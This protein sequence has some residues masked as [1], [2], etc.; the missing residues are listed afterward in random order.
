MGDPEE[1]LSDAERDQAVEW[2]RDHLLSG[3]LTLEEFS[4]R[5]DQAYAARVRADLQQLRLALPSPKEL[6]RG[7][8]HRRAT[9][10]TGAAFGKVVK[11]GRTKRRR[12]TVAGGAF[13]DVD[14]DLCQAA[15]QGRRTT[16]TVLVGLGNVDRL[17]AGERQRH[18]RRSHHR[19]SSARA[20][21]GPRATGLTCDRGPRHLPAEH[22]RRLASTR[23][24]AGRL[25]RDLSSAPGPPARRA[26]V[27][28]WP[29]R[30]A[31]R[32]HRAVR[33]RRAVT[34]PFTQAEPSPGSTLTGPDFCSGSLPGRSSRP[35]PS[36]RPPRLQQSLAVSC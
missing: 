12:W 22:R 7:R 23:E 9:R 36:A 2:L 6:P 26:T 10:L 13:C 28:R 25:W 17:R 3:R 1:R 4:E 5:V 32:R 34:A 33:R 29:Q 11:R 8:S 14:L 35:R 30:T 20:A 18:G 27:I 21:R 31:A 19:G 15:I 24:H 16:A